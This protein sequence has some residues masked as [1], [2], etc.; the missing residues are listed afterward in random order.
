ME[1]RRE[2]RMEGEGG[3]IALEAS[4]GDEQEAGEKEMERKNRE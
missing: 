1:G 3:K 2:E 4:R